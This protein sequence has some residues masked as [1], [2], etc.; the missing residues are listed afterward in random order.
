MTAEV[1]TKPASGCE[2]SPYG[3]KEP[4]ALQLSQIISMVELLMGQWPVAKA[5]NPDVYIGGVASVLFDYPPE[6]VR[7]A[8]DP[9]RGLAVCFPYPPNLADLKGWCE[10]E[11]EP[12][13]REIEAQARRDAAR[14][15]LPAPTQARNTRPTLEQLREKYGPNWGI[16]KPVSLAQ[17]VAAA[18]PQKP[19]SC[20]DGDD[21]FDPSF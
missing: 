5:D 18:L 7:R 2:L 14:R 19:V 16:G 3:P 1:S 10:K 8:V 12:L 11:S 15:S 9:R 13:R 20:E 4:G 17:A 6:I 21:N